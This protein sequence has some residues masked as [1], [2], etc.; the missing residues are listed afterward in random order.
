MPAGP[1]PMTAIFSPNSPSTLGMTFSG[2]KR[3][4]ASRSCWAMNR[5]TSSMATA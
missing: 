2:T 5:F 4:A 1:A 3:V